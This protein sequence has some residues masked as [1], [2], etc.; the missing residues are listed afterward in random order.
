MMGRLLGRGPLSGRSAPT[1]PDVPLEHWAAGYV[2]EASLSHAATGESG[3]ER[4]IGDTA[5]GTW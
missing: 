5:E 2:E 3:G 4:W 1:W